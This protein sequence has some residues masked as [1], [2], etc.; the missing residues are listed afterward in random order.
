[1]GVAVLAIW[2]LVSDWVFAPDWADSLFIATIVFAMSAR[3]LWASMAPRRLVKNRL[4][5]TPP[6]P[7]ADVRREARAALNWPFVI[8][9]LLMSASVF[10]GSM[11]ASDRTMGTWAW[12]IG[13]GAMLGLYLW[14]GVKKLLDRS[15]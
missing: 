6:R 13:S 2:T 11:T 5:V 7:A 1:V 15:R 9:A 8:L 3:L 10:V 4:P 12:L 14:I